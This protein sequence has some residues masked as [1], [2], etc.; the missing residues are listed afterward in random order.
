MARP[1]TVS[2]HGEAMAAYTPAP[3]KVYGAPFVLLEDENLNTFQYVRGAWVPYEKRIAECRLD[4]Q[5]STLPQK[6]NK[7]TRYEIRAPV[8]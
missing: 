7:M 6:V 4:C 1:P 8:N 2:H 5:V 3:K